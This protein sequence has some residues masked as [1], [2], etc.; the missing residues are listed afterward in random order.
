MEESP[1]L[2]FQLTVHSQ[3]YRTPYATSH[4]GASKN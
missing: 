2:H 1:M 4:A 3:Y